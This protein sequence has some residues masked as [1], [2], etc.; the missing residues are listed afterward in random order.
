MPMERKRGGLNDFNS[1]SHMGSYCGSYFLC[2]SRYFRYIFREPYFFLFRFLAF[3]LFCIMGGYRFAEN[4]WLYVLDFPFAA[5]TLWQV[6]CI[7]SYFVVAVFS[8]IFDASLFVNFDSFEQFMCWSV[9]VFAF[10][11]EDN[12]FS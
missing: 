7:Y 6:F 11:S 2:I 5:Y 12:E 3:V 8:W 10:V 1:C 9:A 4:F